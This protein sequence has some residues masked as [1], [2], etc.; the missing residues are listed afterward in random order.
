MTDIDTFIRQFRRADWMDQ[1]ACTGLP[2]ATRDRLFFPQHGASKTLVAQAK[3]MCA[4]CPVRA[5]CLE[6][7]LDGKERFGIWGGKS[8]K[9]RRTMRL[10]RSGRTIAI[11]HGTIGVPMCEPCREA[12]REHKAKYADE[13]VAS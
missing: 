5:A 6:Y 4:D 10:M 8:E 2:T 11:N 13:A 9:E 3:A 1:G 12:G 7:A